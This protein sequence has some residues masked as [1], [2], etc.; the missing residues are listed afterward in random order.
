MAI[1]SLRVCKPVR[2]P[3]I[4]SAFARYGTNACGRLSCPNRHRLDLGALVS[5]KRPATPRIFS[6]STSLSGLPV[7]FSEDN[8]ERAEDCRHIGKHVTFAKKVHCLKVTIGR[9]T[10][11]AFVWPIGSI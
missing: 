6:C 1:E 9:R 11:L 5:A 7:D 8:I 10:N 4:T 3:N 2:K